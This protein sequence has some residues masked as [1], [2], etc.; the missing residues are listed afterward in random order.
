MLKFRNGAIA[1]LRH[2]ATASLLVG[3][4]LFW[5]RKHFRSY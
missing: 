3:K 2:Y 4:L 5:K 1:P